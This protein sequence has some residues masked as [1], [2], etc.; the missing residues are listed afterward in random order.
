[1][2]LQAVYKGREEEGGVKNESIQVNDSGRSFRGREDD[3]KNEVNRD[4]V[5]SL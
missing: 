2:L 3:G 1:L 5:N 4:G